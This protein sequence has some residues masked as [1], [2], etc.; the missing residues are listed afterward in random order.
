MRIPNLIKNTGIYGVFGIL[1]S[2]IPFILLSILTRY[3]TKQ[4]YGLLAVFNIIIMFLGPMLT[5]EMQQALKREYVEKRNGF[6]QYVGTLLFTSSLLLFLFIFLI[7]GLNLFIETFLGL[8]VYW[9][10][11]AF[12]IAFGKGQWLVLMSLFQIQD[13]A[14]LVSIWGLISRVMLFASTVLL[15]VHFGF[16]WEGRAWSEFALNV[17][18][19]GPLCLVLLFKLYDIQWT[20]CW[21]RLKKMLSFSLPLVTVALANYVMMLSDRIFLS[22]MVGLDTVGVYSVAVQISSI[23]ILLSGFFRPSWEAWVFRNLKNET[24]MGNRKTVIALYSFAAFIVFIAV[25]LVWALPFVLQF[26]V[27]E[28][29]RG[30]SDYLT[31]LILGGVF[32]GL[33]VSL[34]PFL[35]YIKKTKV[36]NHIILF[37]AL[38]NCGLN[39]ILIN[40]LGAIGAAVATAI[41]YF[42]ASCLIFSVVRKN[43]NLPWRLA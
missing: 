35:L 26:M 39:F 13:K 17:L 27:G 43:Y 16:S 7:S 18:I 42:I 23:M 15:I 32:F 25:F 11:I 37:V 5:L 36:L 14:L 34:V 31:P 40:K 10:Y 30:A 2:L 22:E 28:S 20:F 38:L 4:D 3:L 1:S 12:F 9:I 33:N 6:N 19:Q 29:F 8:P 21:H 24:E 41:S